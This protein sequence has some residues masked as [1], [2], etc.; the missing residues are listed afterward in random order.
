MLAGSWHETDADGVVNRSVVYDGC[1]ERLLTFEKALAYH[2]DTWGTE[3]IRESRI[4]KVLLVEDTLI[5]FGICRDF[6]DT[7]LDNALAALDV[8]LFLVPSM[9]N[10]RTM[11]GHLTT[12]RL[13]AD[14]SAAR[15]FVVQQSEPE[16]E[17]QLGFVVPP[18]P[19]VAGTPSRGTS[20][21]ST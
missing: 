5:G 1:G 11:D 16:S 2:S 9:G 6:A 18:T 17:D 7:G 10:R 20:T 14:R 19:T 12:A 21:T 4:L 8:D 15:A 13:V 3:D